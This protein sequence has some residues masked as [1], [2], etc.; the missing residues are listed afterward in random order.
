M[1][2]TFNSNRQSAVGN[3]KRAILWLLLFC[4]FVRADWAPAKGPLVTRWVKEVS[5]KNAHPEYPRPQMV[6]NGWRNLNGL[7][8]YAIAPKDDSQPRKY[9]GQILVPFPI[10]SALSGVMKAVG[11]DNRLWY[12]RTFEAPKKWAGRRTLLHFGAVDWD[13]TVWVNGKQVGDHRGGYDPFTFDITDTLKATGPQE[14]VVSVWDPTD[15]GTQP[16]GK[17]VAEPRGIWYTAVTGIWRTVWLEAVPKTYIESIK[18]VPDLD[19]ASVRLVAKC[20]GETAACRIEARAKDWLFTRGKGQGKPGEEFVVKIKT[21][22]LWS[23]DSPFLYD[24]TLTLKDENGK[25][26]DSVDSYF[27]MRKIEVKKDKDGINRLWLNNKVLFQFGLLDQG[28]WPDG[29]YAAPT[30]A[31]LRYDI[32]TLKKLG[33]NMLRKH[34]KVE[35]DRLYYWCDKLGLMVWQDMPNGDRHIRGNQRDIERSEESA[36][37]FELELTRV[38]EAYR[39]HPCIVMWVPFNE[40]WGQYDT[41]RIVDLIRGIDPSRLVDNAS[42]WADRGVGDVSDIHRY[43]GPAA[44]P[45]EEKRAGVLGEF[46]GLG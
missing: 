22:Q 42:G 4:S 25:T 19:S 1:D 28:W 29:L 37:Q 39:N 44:P 18:I 30:D 8:E 35:P 5:P 6:R 17:Q 23:P 34:V 45:T 20:S 24:L 10:E 32:E 43:P 11:Q 13:A 46:G 40:G 41:A 15:A 2:S 21:P 3:C 26:L 14:L 27:G 7:W 12:R 36:K 31:A 9:D 33:C 16:R 38:I